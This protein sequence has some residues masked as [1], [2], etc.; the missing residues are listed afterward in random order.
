MQVLEILADEGE[1]RF[2]RLSERIPGIS[3]KMPLRTARLQGGLGATGGLM[4]QGG[5][6]EA[7]GTMIV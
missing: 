2:T 6:E 4:D 5:V 7:G 3:Q 1:Q